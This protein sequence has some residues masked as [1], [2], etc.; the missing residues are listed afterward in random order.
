MKCKVGGAGGEGWWVLLGIWFLITLGFL[1]EIILQH[2]LSYMVWGHWLYIVNIHLHG[3]LL[4]SSSS[5]SGLKWQQDH[6]IS[7]SLSWGFHRLFVECVSGISQEEGAGTITSHVNP[8]KTSQELE[9]STFLYTRTQRISCSDLFVFLSLSREQWGEQ[10]VIKCVF[11]LQWS[12][13]LP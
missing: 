8:I 1:L 2:Y 5:G 13:R 10:N 12:S 3:P 11:A 6:T 9:P 4:W 7:W